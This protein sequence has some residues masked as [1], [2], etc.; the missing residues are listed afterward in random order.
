M[1]LVT[2][3]WLTVPELFSGSAL[4]SVERSLLDFESEEAMS[5]LFASGFLAASVGYELKKKPQ[6]IF[7]CK[8]V[9]V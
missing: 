3:E 1:L 8:K 6:L 9:Y 5:T 7:R 4:I 2:A